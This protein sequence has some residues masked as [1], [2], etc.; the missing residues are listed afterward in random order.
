[1]SG[2]DLTM[3][4]L[5]EKIKQSEINMWEAAINRSSSSFLE[6]VSEN[7]VMV[8]G[9]YRCLGSEYAQVIEEF[10]L[11]GYEIVAYETIIA[12][13]N[14]VQNHYVICTKVS[15]GENQDLAGTFHIT[16]TWQKQQEKWKLIYNMDSKIEL[17]SELHKIN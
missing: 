7:A 16:S 5:S 2:K 14:L 1:M 15:E 6:L 12:T 9:G 4:N 8:C 10:N 11:S 13:E 3:E 17:L